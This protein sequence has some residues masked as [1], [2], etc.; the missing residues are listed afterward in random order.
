MERN[1]GGMCGDSYTM[2]GELI[3]EELL[4]KKIMATIILSIGISLM[5]VGT[6]G[7]FVLPVEAATTQETSIQEGLE[8]QNSSTEETQDTDNNSTAEGS[9]NDVPT[10][11]Y[12]PVNVK[13]DYHAIMLTGLLSMIAAA[14]GALLAIKW[15]KNKEEK[16]SALLLYSDLKSIESYII[17]DNQATNLRYSESWQKAMV[18]CQFFSISDIKWLFSFYDTSYDFNYLFEEHRK[19]KSV[20]WQEKYEEMKRK[21]FNEKDEYTNEYNEILRK[22]ENKLKTKDF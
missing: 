10:I 16:H 17:K 19:D 15:S 6:S 4:M 12:L 21:M 20:S 11:P 14:I 2:F 8:G 13:T 18:D 9:S 3:R 7:V 1:D 5:A 22:I